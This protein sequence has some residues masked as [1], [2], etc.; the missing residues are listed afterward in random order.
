MFF[1][2]FE[3]CIIN[4]MVLHFAANTDF[5]KRRQAH[6][7]FRIQLAQELVQPLLDTKAQVGNVVHCPVPGRRSFENDK[8]LQGKHF[9]ESRHPKRGC[10]VC[11]G[12]KKG[13]NKKYKDKKTSNFY[14]KCDQFVCK[15]CF[16]N[17]HTKSFV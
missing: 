9:A 3:L 14:L 17:Y 2:L 13:T 8:R 11:C 12:Y 10:C 4:A 7:L 6:E 1:R 5:A 15:N 16:E